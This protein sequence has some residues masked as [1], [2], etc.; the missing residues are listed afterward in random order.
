MTAGQRGGAGPP[1]WAEAGRLFTQRIARGDIVE[2]LE[3]GD[4]PVGTRHVHE[5]A[6]CFALDQYVDRYATI[7]EAS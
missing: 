7:L 4:T 2:I 1:A 6:E 5:G 3:L